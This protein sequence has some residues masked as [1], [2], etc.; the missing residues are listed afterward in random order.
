MLDMLN[1]LTGRLYYGLIAPLFAFFV[2]FLN[3][4]FVKPLMFLHFPLW[5]HISL[6]GVLTA[7]LSLYLR[8]RLHAEEKSREFNTVF[9]EKRRRQHDLQLITEK[10]S[11]EALYKATD[12][13][14][15]DDFNTYLAH[16]YARYV[17]IYLLPVFLVMAWLNSVFSE[18]ML[19]SRLGHPFVLKVPANSFGISGLSVTSVFLLTYVLCL[20]IGFQILRRRKRGK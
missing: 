7:L 3:V 19:L 4:V 16:H 11:R 20:I 12:E 6:L 15:N 2:S 10:H 5:L 17:M 8:K 18:S 14:L 13:E 9:A 1:D